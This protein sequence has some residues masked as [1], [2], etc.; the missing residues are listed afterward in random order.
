MRLSCTELVGNGGKERSGFFTSGGGVAVLL[1][2]VLGLVSLGGASNKEAILAEVVLEALQALV[3]KTL[4]R[5]SLACGAAHAVSH[6]C[7]E[8]INCV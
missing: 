1:H 3:A 4:Q 6:L 2:R 8:V 5:R 7:S